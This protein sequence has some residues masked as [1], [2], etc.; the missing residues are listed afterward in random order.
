MRNIYL[1]IFVKLNVVLIFGFSFWQQ[2]FSQSPNIS[3]SVSGKLVFSPGS[4]IVPLVPT[5]TG[6]QVYYDTQK[7]VAGNGNAGAVDGHGIFASFNRPGGIVVDNLG[8]IYVADYL[9]H[10]IRKILPSGDVTTLSG[11]GSPDVVNGPIPLARF[12]Y[13]YEIAL[14]KFG[15]LYVSEDANQIRKISNQTMVSTLAGGS[16]FPGYADGPGTQAQFNLPSGMDVDE[17]SNLYVADSENH[18]IRKITPQGMVTTFAGAGWVGM[19]NGVGTEA[20]FN[21]PSSVAVDSHDNVYV[22]DRN[23]YV[24]RKISPAGLV[25]TFA[26]SGTPAEVDGIGLAASFYPPLDIAIDAFDNLYIVCEGTSS[27]RKISPEGKVSTIVGRLGLN[28]GTPTSI[29]VDDKGN[30]FIANQENKILKVE[31]IGYTISPSLPE[32][33]VFDRA[34]G[35]ISGQPSQLS[36]ETIY[37]V[38]A[39]NG[40]GSHTTI[41]NIAVGSIPAEPTVLAPAISY[42][43]PANF[44][45]GSAITPLIPNNTGGP[46]GSEGPIESILAGSG[47]AGAE[48]GVGTAATFN[49]PSGLAVDAVGTVYVADYNNHQIRKVMPDGTVTTLAGNTVP[50]STDGNLSEAQFDRPFGITVDAWGNLYVSEDVN[51]IRKITGGVVSTFAGSYWSGDDNG[52]GTAAKFNLPSG[53][54]NDRNGNVYVADYSNNKIR[55]ITPS[56]L[57]TT[58]AGNLAAGALDG[59]AANATFNGPTSI[60]VDGDD[61]IFV[62]DFNNH[63][64]RKITP[65]GVVSTFAGSGVDGVED[66]LGTASSFSHPMDIDVDKYGNVY[67]ICSGMSTVRKITAQG[68]V[69]T[70]VNPSS[71]FDYLTAISLDK[72]GNIYVCNAQSQI[73]L[74]KS[75]AFK[76]SPSLPAGLSFDVLNGK[77]SGTPTAV[78][79]LTTY[80]ITAL[81]AGGS[82]VTTLDIAVSLPVGCVN[83]SQDQNYI[84]TY[85]PLVKDL[86]SEF[87]IIGASC[88]KMKVQ[89]DI[90]YIDGLGR[91]LQN[92]QVKGSGDGLKDLVVPIA[93]DSFGREMRKYLPYASTTNNGVY[94]ADGLT[95]VIDYY[96][97]PQAGHAVTFN[98]PFSETKFEL[99]P[100]SRV[101]E[102][103]APGASW[104]IGGHTSKLVYGANTIDQNFSTTGFAVRLF[105]AVLV[106]TSGHTHER[107]LSSTG[108]YEASQLFLVVSKDENWV[109]TDG[110]A[111]TVEEY[112]DKEGQIVLKRI[113]NRTATDVIEVLST[114]YVYDDFGNLSFVLP[115]G[116]N[117]DAGSISQTTLDNFCYQYRY[118]GRNRLIE[119]KLPGKGWEYMVYNKI[120]QLVLSQ[121]ANQRLEN[122]WLYSKY[123]GLGRL[124]STGIYSGISTSNRSGLQT[125]VDAQTIN[126]WESRDAGAEYSNAVFPTS[127]TE[128]LTVNYYDNYNFP[129]GNA[130]SYAAGSAMIKGLLTGTKVKV[131]GTSTMLLSLTFY[132]NKGRAEKVFQQHYLSGAQNAQNYD[133]VKNTYSFTDQLLESTRIHHVGANQTSIVNKYTYDHM[134]RKLLTKESINAATEVILSK[135]DYNE[136][137]QLLTKSIHSE[138]DTN[139]TQHNGYLYNER[140]W[141]NKINDPSALDG[142][143]VFGMELLYGNKADAFNGN[144]GGI[145]W[146]T[147]VPVGM[148]LIEQLQSYVYDYDK[149][150]RLEKAGY[151]TAGTVDKF[152][153]VLKY[154][155]MGNMTN[156][157]RKNN[158]S[159]F[160]NDFTYNYGVNGNSG[161][162]LLGVTD[163]GTAA[164]GSSY[165]YDE[166]G[167]QK[168]DSRKAI[169]INYNLLNLPQIITKTG[170]AATL[171]YVY[172]ATGRKL[173]KV[174]GTD[175]RDYIGG[176]EYHNGV[177][178]FIQTEEGRALPAAGSAYSYEYM[179]K[180]H[181]GNTRATIKQ[182]GDIIQVQDY[183]AF[184]LEMNAGNNLTPSPANKYKY[185]GKEKQDELG[186]DQLDYGAR[187]YDPVIGRFSTIDPLSEISRRNSPYSY[188]LNNPIRF[189]DVDGMFADEPTPEEAALI[190]AH[191]YGSAEDNIKLK[192]GWAVSNRDVGLKASDYTNSNTGIKSALYERTVD[193]KTEYVYATAGTE[194]VD[195]KDTKDVVANAA[196]VF[197]TSAQYDKSVDNAKAIKTSLGSSELTYVGHSLGGGEASVNAI[198]TGDKAMTFNASGISIPTKMKYGGFMAGFN[199]FS[200]KVTAYQLKSD[201][202][203]IL[204]DATLLPGAVGTVKMISPKGSAAKRDGHS[205]LSVIKSIR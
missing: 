9:N 45:A 122:K 54:A 157:K 43:G 195:I 172:D 101:E 103:G 149:L 186:L 78:S 97:A 42:A 79:A 196:Q 20:S 52:Q 145:N 12:F 46:V 200:D 21:S 111:G 146:K 13:P 16:F 34:S 182:N 7:L 108:F 133:E 150:N 86:N 201:P 179:L 127:S 87:A 82:S 26:G 161:N 49:F 83:P 22:A 55:K 76:I 1:N 71:D 112:K 151:T 203:T 155:Q 105:D 93:Y 8:V 136:I 164:Q 199:S 72:A 113:F 29:A 95:K 129:G 51:V 48:N 188:A 70:L 84:L 44:I 119:K 80:T 94:K 132:D 153:E 61:N 134:R 192:G 74:I 106:T 23:N 5:N 169:S 116:A 50:G 156:L 36:S 140:G 114:Y 154:D 158:V 81:N 57:V 178:E 124:V 19:F 67:V 191:V 187:F 193:G 68:E 32:G 168:T 38:T 31:A 128:E 120:D 2:G 139:F 99:S 135:L 60:A 37:T 39:T 35:T 18:C 175:V 117:P 3:Y 184:G 92:V 47:V 102:Q 90:Q 198:V 33:L 110:K 104:Q 147:K 58:V 14:D 53:M 171:G 176:I 144:I 65:A 185:N 30:I 148:G 109:I 89:A 27:I 69:T 96:N 138:D 141:L 142:S 59:L 115:P 189:I 125:T 56:G 63:K 28:P 17:M 40:S 4:Q 10:L 180:D 162:Q 98:T 131:L 165:T 107:T 62:A 77:I 85:T 181:L 73:L 152:N 118:D 159:G 75:E 194:M 66:G 41:L 11:N 126:L 197:G 130:Y 167:N 170:T 160:L 143:T 6:G 121:D 174:F 123:D 166:N 137:G 25:T 190:A 88:D 64:I 15:N 204:Q 24:I 173:K 177:I 163:L 205:I 91:P 100:L 183:Y 202:L